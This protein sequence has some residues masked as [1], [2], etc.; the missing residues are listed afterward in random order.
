MAVAAVML[1]AG[2]ANAQIAIHAG[3]QNGTV[4]ASGNGVT[5]VA[6][7]GANG[8]YAGLDYNIAISGDDFGIAPGAM[9]SYYSDMMD[10]RIPV[11]LN[12]REQFNTI[13]VGVQAGPTFN[14]GLAGDMYK[15]P[16]K[17][18]RFD[19]ALG[20]GIWLGYEKIRL[21]VGYSYGLLNR[22]D[23]SGD[24]SWRFHKLYVGLGYAL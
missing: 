4:S 10:L 5:V 19:I 9:F 6:N 20:A 18:K 23:G 7:D 22:F 14:I 15:D 17:A 3:Y 8:F 1:F 16:I 12:W 21:E 11:M 24:Y 13:E 2:K